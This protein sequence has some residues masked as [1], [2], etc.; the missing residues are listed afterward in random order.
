MNWKTPVTMSMMPAKPIHPVHAL[1]VDAGG[2]CGGGYTCWP[3]DDIDGSVMT[4][5]LWCTG[6]AHWPFGVDAGGGRHGLVP[7][8]MEQM[9]EQV[10]REHVSRGIGGARWR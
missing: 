5:L 2:L 8:M 6:H 3:A 7:R 10:R 4:S 1:P 9:D